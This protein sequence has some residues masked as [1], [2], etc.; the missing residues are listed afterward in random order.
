MK[1]ILVG[2]LMFYSTSGKDDVICPH[3]GCFVV[4]TY[5]DTQFQLSAILH[6]CTCLYLPDTSGHIPA[7]VQAVTLKTFN[8]MPN[9]KSANRTID[10]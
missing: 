4:K 5:A 7:G 9:L 10:A 2:N 6:S 3:M 1:S 8:C